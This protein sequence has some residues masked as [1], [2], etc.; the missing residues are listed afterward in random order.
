MTGFPTT[1][2]YTI[3]NPNIM[4]V[5]R[6]KTTANHPPV[7]TIFLGGINHTINRW[8]KNHSQMGSLWHGFTHIKS[9]FSWDWFKGETGNHGFYPK[10]SGFTVKFPL[11]QSNQVPHF[12]WTFPW[13][14]PSRSHRSD[15]AM[16]MQRSAGSGSCFPCTLRR[17]R[18]R[19][20]ESPV[21]HFQ[22]Y[23]YSYKIPKKSLRFKE[24]SVEFY[25][26]LFRAGLGSAQTAGP[27]ARLHSVLH[28]LMCPHR[29][30]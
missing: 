26:D 24:C 23:S 13:V 14:A 1:Y 22:L 7:I 18:P 27:E 28:Q 17:L 3:Y 25:K 5:R 10:I 4:W 19:K 16:Q 12:Q 8:Y 9:Q 21:P 11:N 30:G 2:Q 6:G 29:H 15:P 20:K